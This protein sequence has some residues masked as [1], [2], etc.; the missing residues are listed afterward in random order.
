[1]KFHRL[2]CRERAAWMSSAQSAITLRMAQINEEAA[3][4]LFSIISRLSKQLCKLLFVVAFHFFDTYWL[5]A[6][7]FRLIALF[8]DKKAR[9]L[10]LAREW[11][12]KIPC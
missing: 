9:R 2:K 12:A 3:A 5:P 7:T 10:H 4:V 6:Y 1:M 8:P 11:A